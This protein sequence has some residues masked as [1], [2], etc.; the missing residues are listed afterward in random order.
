MS[1]T[2]VRSYVAK[3]G[4]IASYRN[5]ADCLLR[6]VKEVMADGAAPVR[7]RAYRSDARQLSIK[8]G[9]AD[10]ILTSPPYFSVH[11][12]ARDNWLRL[13]FLGFEDYREVQQELIQTAEVERYR[14]EMKAAFREMHRVLRPRGRAL[15]LV[16]DVTLPTA[17]TPKRVIRTANLL[18]QDAENCGFRCE[19]ILEDQIPQRFKVVGYMAPDGGIRTERLLVLK[20][21]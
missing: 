4:L 20:S 8:D 21:A 19:A 16:G 14:T 15:V 3:H 7:G 17:K 9:V 11:R 1:P 12:Y 13:W 18:A 10:L 6:R 2:Y 5:V